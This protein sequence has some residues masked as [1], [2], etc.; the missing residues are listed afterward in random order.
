[1]GGG[2]GPPCIFLAAPLLPLSRTIPT[3]FPLHLHAMPWRLLT[4]GP[5]A[6]RDLSPL[7]AE[8]PLGEYAKMVEFSRHRREVR[9]CVR[10]SYSARCVVAATGANHFLST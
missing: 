6:E 8:D 1:M 5:L 7:G 9:A 10:A 3:H 4:V 2:R